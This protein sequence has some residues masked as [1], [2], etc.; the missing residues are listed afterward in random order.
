[1]SDPV[2]KLRVI[3]DSP[4][5]SDE[6]VRLGDRG[7]KVEPVERLPGKRE[8]EGEAAERLESVA[9][10]N[11]EGRSQEPGVEAIL[12]T[13]EVAEHVEQPWGIG[14]GRLAGVPYGW[15]V[16]IALAVAGGGIWSAVAMRRGE[17][18]LKVHHG[19]I[20]ELVAND[21]QEI[22]AATELVERVEQL[23]KDYLKADTMEE[24]LPLVRDPERVRPMIEQEWEDRPKR[25]LGF[26]R[27]TLFEPATLGTRPFWVVRAEVED[28]EA[29]S[30]LVEQSGD[31]G[32]KVDWET[33][34]CRQP[35][36]WDRYVTAR[37]EGEAL[38]FRVWAVADAYYSH[39]FSD[40]G[41]WRC[42]R[43]SAKGSEEHLFGYALAGSDAAEGLLALGRSSPG[44]KATVMLRLRRPTGT[45]SPRGVVIER[46]V[47]P[48]WLVLE[49]LPADSP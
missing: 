10:E 24:L 13:Q 9:R 39:E 42:F 44:G 38:D 15:F 31:H 18:Q 35:M 1:M 48:R 4:S 8:W 47:A 11:F 17:M 29:Q 5:E 2:P 7:A 33:H 3:E 46:L 6:V 34:V 20:R 43:L 22:E 26:L 32:V 30:L 19:E 23:V 16:L 12:E 41:R 21:E 36:P 25:S 28:G 27:M 45:A 14:D 37:P 49:D 40:G